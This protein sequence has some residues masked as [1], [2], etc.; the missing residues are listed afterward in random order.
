M[1]ALAGFAASLVAYFV[2]SHWAQHPGWWPHLW[3]S[4]IEQHYN[5]DGFEPPFS[6]AAYLRAFAVSVVRAVNV[7]GWVGVSVLALAG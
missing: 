6:T 1:G 3:F 7:D 4:S 5:M 2:I